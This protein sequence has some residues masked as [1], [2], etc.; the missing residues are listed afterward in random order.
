MSIRNRVFFLAVLILLYPLAGTLFLKEN[1]RITRSLDASYLKDRL[2]DIAKLIT[3]NLEP[4]EGPR[5]LSINNIEKAVFFSPIKSAPLLD[6]YA[7]DE[8][9]DIPKQTLVDATND[10]SVTWQ[11]AIVSDSLFLLFTVK[12]KTFHPHNYQRSLLA[13]GDHLG[14]RL[15]DNR[16]Y[17]LRLSS[18]GQIISYYLNSIDKQINSDVITAYWHRTDKGYQLELR[19]DIENARDR[20]GFFAVNAAIKYQKRVE[21][22]SV[23][24][25]LTARERLDG[26]HRIIDAAL[27][28][29]YQS[30][31]F[32]LAST[33]DHI[34]SEGMRLHVVDSQ[35]HVIATA[36]EFSVDGTGDDIPW[37]MKEIYRAILANKAT[38]Q[39]NREAL[40]NCSQLLNTNKREEIY[41]KEGLSFW[42]QEY[43]NDLMSYAAMPLNEGPYAGNILIAEQGRDRYVMLT[44]PIFLY[45]TLALIGISALI[46]LVTFIAMN[47]WS[48]RLA[49]LN[50]NAQR[51]VDEK[52][53]ITGDFDTDVSNDEIGQLSRNVGDL[54]GQIKTHND[55]LKTLAQKL[56]HEMQTPLAIVSTSLD[57]IDSKNESKIGK[58]N[59]VYLNRARD[60]I[61]R[62]S[63]IMSAM[64]QAKKIEQSIESAECEPVDV[65]ALLQE[66]CHSY[67]GVYPKHPVL[68]SDK[69][70]TNSLI[71]NASAD[72]LIQ[73]LDKLVDNAIGFSSDGSAVKVDLLVSN[74]HLEI[75]V[76]NTGSQLPEA[77]VDGLFQQLVSYRHKTDDK[78]HLGL[79]LFIARLI[80]EYHKGSINAFNLDDQSG[81]SFNVKLPIT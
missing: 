27:A 33:L 46:V 11:A 5:P 73:L 81:V 6:G 34:V 79:G 40:F 66:A 10:L 15:G 38:E 32:S 58:D 3:F 29:R 65:V 13:N 76:I 59:D 4:S 68:F 37:F 17:Y 2:E 47:R 53:D 55:Y 63:H 45:F 80:A 77:G 54:L 71:I 8:W 20:I 61:Q 21:P 28:P 49:I 52:G 60:G 41:G 25:N 70:N 39:Y 50:D 78:P 56:S 7:D 16:T 19:V 44:N 1:E 48:N 42:S 74:K 67:H 51:H 9:S 57:N 23:V 36:G 31:A 14:I 62:L 26:I 43:K 12:D 35:C 72:L 75:Q 30:Y 64:G 69:N 18:P 24:A 22:S